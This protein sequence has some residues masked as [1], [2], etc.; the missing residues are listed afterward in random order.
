MGHPWYRR[1]AGVLWWWPRMVVFT[2]GIIDTSPSEAHARF[3]SPR[4]QAPRVWVPAGRS[5]S[6]AHRAGYRLVGGGTLL[7]F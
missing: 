3:L 2:S 1:L 4:W 5:V 7:G 6:C